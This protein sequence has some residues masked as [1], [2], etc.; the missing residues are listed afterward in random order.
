MGRWG[1]EVPEGKLIIEAHVAGAGVGRLDV[2]CLIG[3]EGVAVGVEAKVRGGG[4]RSLA[5]DEAKS[6]RK[7]VKRSR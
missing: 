2:P 1:L 4:G 6:G 5:E 7:I 3:L